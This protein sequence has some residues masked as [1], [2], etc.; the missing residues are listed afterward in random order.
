MTNNEHEEIYFADDGIFDKIS[1]IL[2]KNSIE[3]SPIDAAFNEGK[4]FI[5]IT[6]N[7]IK[8]LAREK[9][10]EDDFVISLQKEIG[11]SKKMA[12]N[13]LKAVK[14]NIL[15]LAQKIKIKDDQDKKI[16]AS[17]V[18]ETPTGEP[19]SNLRSRKNIAPNIKPILPKPNISKGE[20][21][22]KPEKFKKMEVPPAKEQKAADNK[23]GDSYRE[24]I[25]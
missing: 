4:S 1:K 13:I 11:V 16:D 2:S 12:E 19:I 25:E 6:L 24:P 22:E 15:P 20:I 17:V 10:S 7:L 9:V 3:E 14:E 21:I 8:D 18:I 23:Q 5:L